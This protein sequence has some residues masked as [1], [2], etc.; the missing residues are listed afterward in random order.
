MNT[1][2]RRL[3][4][5]ATPI[6]AV[7][8]APPLAFAA[9]S[10]EGAPAAAPAE[11]P[12]APTLKPR[13]ARIFSRVREALQSEDY[14][15][16]SEQLDRLVLRKANAYER[17]QASRLRGFIAYGQE[18]NTEAIDHLNAA[19][20]EG[21]LPPADRADTLFQ[22]AQI[23]AGEKRWADVIASLEDWFQIIERPNS[24]GY[25]MLALANFQ[26]G[27]VDAALLP[28]K[29]AVEIAERP[30][31][32]WMQLLLALHLTQKDYASAAPVLARMLELY[33]N[34]GKD[35][36]LQLSA[37]YGAIDDPARSLGVLELAHRQGLLTEDRDLRRLLQ[38]TLARGIPE[39]AAEI[40]EREIAAQRIR[41]DAE[42]LE[43]LSASYILARDIDA[44]D[45]PL[46]RAAELSDDGDLWVRAGQIHMLQEEWSEATLAFHNAIAKGGLESPGN[47]Q[48]LLGIAYYNEKK[49]D[50]ARGAFVL[51]QRQAPTREQAQAWIEHIDRE[52]AGVGV[53]SNWGG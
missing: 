25:F 19:I 3:S 26:M 48:L 10:G 4:L 28:A 40:F 36:W 5:L 29:K 11:A 53:A 14:S 41:E 33:P 45:A 12:A 31:A 24:V 9:V 37:L 22:V 43:L 42:S 52:R 17:A 49:L 20:A 21:G 15:E 34:S 35:Y 8:L 27:D 2:L 46:A 47:A 13:T 18:H 50:A 38:L 32:T 44:A 16:A 39:R 1:H 51:A 7:Q 30:Q 6:L 23:Q